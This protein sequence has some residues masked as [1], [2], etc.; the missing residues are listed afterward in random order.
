[1]WCVFRNSWCNQIHQRSWLQSD[2]A[3]SKQITMCMCRCLVVNHHFDNAFHTCIDNA[4]DNAFQHFNNPYPNCL[5]KNERNN[6]DF[7]STKKHFFVPLPSF[8]TFK[9]DWWKFQV[10]SNKVSSPLY[11]RVKLCLSK[12]KHTPKKKMPIF[13]RCACNPRDSYLLWKDVGSCTWFN[14]AD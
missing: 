12:G 2:R 5:P 3:I 4:F 14:L 11:R 9:C 1:M 6:W 7:S 10:G 8:Q 13:P